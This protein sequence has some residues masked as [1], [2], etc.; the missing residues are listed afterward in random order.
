[1][2][3]VLH[4]LVTTSPGGGPKHVYDLVRH[5]PPDEVEAVVAAPRDGIFFDRFRELGVTMVELP[6]SR[7][8]VR[9]LPLTIELARRHRVDIVHTHGKGPGLYGRLA[10]R[11]LGVAAVHTFH[12][13]HYGSYPRTGQ[14]LYFL[15][16][17]RLSR[18]SDAIINVSAAQEAEGLALGLFRPEQS[19][20]VVNGI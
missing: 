4:L 17:R 16:E 11:W 13:I 20:V 14:A 19:T 8:G 15:L 3:R 18:L 7:L 6:L 2:I 10:A 9:H 12:G 5:L 1:P